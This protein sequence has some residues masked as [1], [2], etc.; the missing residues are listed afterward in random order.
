MSK[1]LLIKSCSDPMLW[2]A[3]K[4]GQCVPFLGVWREAYKS[5]EPK[6]YIN[7]V[8]FQDAEIIDEPV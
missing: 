1:A 5:R 2:Y 4:I 7:I 6:G 3:D 8:N